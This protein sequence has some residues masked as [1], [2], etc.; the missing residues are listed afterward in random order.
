MTR[1]TIPKA[2]DLHRDKWG[3]VATAAAVGTTPEHDDRPVPEPDD[4]AVVAAVVI[5]FWGYDGSWEQVPNLYLDE[6]DRP[7]CDWRRWGLS[8]YDGPPIPRDAPRSERRISYSFERPRYDSGGV[9]IET[10][11]SFRGGGG[12]SALCRV[13]RDAEGW[14]VDG[15]TITGLS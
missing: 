14:Y 11:V 15:A 4:C 9:L 12:Y 6:G 10:A 13:R 5:Q 2:E 8:F 1:R 3:D 7:E